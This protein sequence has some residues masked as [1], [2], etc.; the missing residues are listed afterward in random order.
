MWVILLEKA[1]AKVYGSY[2]DIVGGDPVHALRDLT[3]APFE[4]IENFSNLDN[5]WT[6]LLKANSKNYILTCFTKST[7]I[8]EEQDK[9]G[10]VYGHAYSILDV[11]DI[12][13][14]RGKAARVLQIRNPWGKF[15]WRGDFS[16]NS[17]LW[18]PAHKR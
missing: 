9:L 13:D 4:R 17:S 3:G 6:K 10:I 15:E 5:V 14:S 1:Y 2:W 8:N 18:T 7:S 16:D 11:E 12:V